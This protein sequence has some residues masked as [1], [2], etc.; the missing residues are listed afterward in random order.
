MLSF[1]MIVIKVLRD[2]SKHSCV[3]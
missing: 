2:K 1:E 3:Y